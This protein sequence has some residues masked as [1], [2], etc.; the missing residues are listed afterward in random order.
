ME[1]GG[2][3][4]RINNDKRGKS[5]MQSC[6]VEGKR[7]FNAA[8]EHEGAVSSVTMGMKDVSAWTCFGKRRKE[9]KASRLCEFAG[10]GR[11]IG[12]GREKGFTQART[13]EGKGQ[14]PGAA[15]ERKERR[16]GKIGI[17]I[18]EN[19]YPYILGY[20][21]EGEAGLLITIH[22]N[23]E[24]QE[25]I[26]TKRPREISRKGGNYSNQEPP[27]GQAICFARRAGEAVD[28][29]EKGN[30]H[31]NRIIEGKGRRCSRS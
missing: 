7:Q 16:K 22:H 9:G 12:G 13:I 8:R 20:A 29:K 11:L 6:A 21:E 2:Q 17:S 28:A 3:G 4:G 15:E 23:P 24:A 26:G 27:P 1:V 31:F 30:Y 14:R 18:G 5:T 10:A 19:G 25:N